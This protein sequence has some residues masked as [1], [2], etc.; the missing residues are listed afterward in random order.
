MVLVYGSCGGCQTASSCLCLYG[1][2]RGV[3]ILCWAVVPWL[4]RQIF[5][6]TLVSGVDWWE[7]YVFLVSVSEVGGSGGHQRGFLS[8]LDTGNLTWI[9]CWVTLVVNSLMCVRGVS[10]FSAEFFVTTCFI[11]VVVV[12]SSVTGGVDSVSSKT[13]VYDMLFWWNQVSK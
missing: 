2:A 13:W 3:E 1:L 4:T 6:D 7:Y 9:S 5:L 10:L 8:W 12:C 11:E